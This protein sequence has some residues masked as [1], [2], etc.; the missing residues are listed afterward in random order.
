MKIVKE[1]EESKDG[2]I[3][4]ESRIN[5]MTLEKREGNDR[6]RESKKKAEKKKYK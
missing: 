2:A 6:L 1:E 4:E 5:R 3:Y